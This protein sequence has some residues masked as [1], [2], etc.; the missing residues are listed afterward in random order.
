MVT[1]AVIDAEEDDNKA[2]VKGCEKRKWLVD[3]LDSEI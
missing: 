3:I 2:L 1:M